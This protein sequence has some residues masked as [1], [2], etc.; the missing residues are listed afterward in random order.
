METDNEMFWPYMFF[1]AMICL[2][3]PLR[4]TIEEI[5]N[6]RRNARM[7]ELQIELQE[8]VLNMEIQERLGLEDFSKYMVEINKDDIEQ[9]ECVICFG[10]FRERDTIILRCGHFYHR[11]CINQ[12]FNYRDTCPICRKSCKF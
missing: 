3:C 12:W 9:E 7:N 11:N 10:D 5:R 6:R 8:V 2:T 4:L 1:V